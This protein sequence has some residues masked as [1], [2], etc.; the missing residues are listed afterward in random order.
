MIE[1]HY[2][3]PQDI[4]WAYEKGDLYILQ[5]RRARVAGE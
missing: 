4:E 5:A 2:G 1:D 3:Y